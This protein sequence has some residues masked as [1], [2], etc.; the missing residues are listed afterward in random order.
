MTQQPPAPGIAPDGLA[1]EPSP[2]SENQV[3][4]DRHATQQLQRGTSHRSRVSRNER[5]ASTTSQV[6][7]D[8][9]GGYA[10]LDDQPPVQNPDD[11]EL[12][13]RQTT[14]RPDSAGDNV[15]SRTLSS[16]SSTRQARL[17][18]RRSSAAQVDY[19]VPDLYA[20]LDEVAA[21]SPVQNPEEEP[22]YRH[23]SLEEVR[24]Q[25]AQDRRRRSRAESKEPSFGGRVPG[26]PDARTRAEDSS[27]FKVS[28]LATQ[29]YTI[30][31][32]IFFS[33]LGTL[34]RLGLQA[35]TYYP[36][37]PVIFSS[38]WPNF[39][40]SLI[41]GFLAEDRMLFSHE[42]GVPMYAAEV[43]KAREQNGKEEESGG[44]A[45]D[46]PAAAN[47]AAAKKAYAATKKTIPL[48]IGL[49]TG[50]CGSFTS[51]SS[52]IRDV[53][54]ALSN[55]LA[56]PDTAAP[57]PRNGGYS[58]MALVAVILLTV[59]MSL[60][61][62]FIGA[63]LAIATEPLVPALPFLFMRKF[64]D[65]CAV[66]LGWGCWLGAVLLSALPPDRDDPGPET[67]RGRAT[68]AL[69]FAPLGCLARFYASL[70]LNGKIAS[71]PL[72]TFAVN[73]SGSIVL[74]MAWTLA[75]V[76]LGGVVGCQ[77]LQGIEDGFCGCLTTVSTWVA[78]LSSLRRR[79]A[80]VYGCASVIVSLAF[81]VAIMGGL[82]WSDG[83]AEL[84]CLH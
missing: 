30:S 64:L 54:L 33:I 80:Y 24:S 65:R 50:F 36:G 42:W 63:H 27:A 40:G 51:F 31:Y 39:T 53:F 58:F 21:G 28:R 23:Q 79:H 55:D 5:R 76:P 15:I 66:V 71:F 48:Y 6:D 78:E 22:V 2:T 19:D 60:S 49:A 16:T 47:L 7:Y 41:I 81:M 3:E 10:D 32:L 44:S 67:W 43:R 75:H 74:A 72:G 84:R 37:A 73:V 26:I 59:S 61:G 14:G 77:V 62:L 25:D 68:F 82:R 52:F 34:A 20:N 38:I 1:Q 83:F 8:L 35:L 69:V 17:A 11:D 9:P 18:R 4:S 57:V 45:S 29:L 56:T 12:V 13:R 70:Y 46:S